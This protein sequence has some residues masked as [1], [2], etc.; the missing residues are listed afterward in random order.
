VAEMIMSRG[1][2]QSSKSL[3]WSYTAVQRSSEAT[4]KKNETDLRC[5]TS[6]IFV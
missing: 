5:C 3:V 2:R 1:R 6:W 4:A